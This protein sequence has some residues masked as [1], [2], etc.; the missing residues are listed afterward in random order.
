MERLKNIIYIISYVFMIAALLVTAVFYRQP[1]VSILLVFM[2]ILPGI[3]LFF[4]H[5]GSEQISLSASAPSGDICEGDAFVIRLKLKN[6]SPVP[7]LRCSLEYSFYNL[8]KKDEKKYVITLPGESFASENYN[9][10]F[11]AGCAGMFVFEGRELLISD[12][13][14]FHT[15]RKK[16]D[17]NISI[18]VMPPE[19]PIPE[20][21]LSRYEGEPLDD[22]ISENGELTRDIRQLREYRAGDRLKDIHWKASASSGELM[23]KEYER[24]VDLSYLLLPETVKGDEENVLRRYYSLGKKLIGTGQ[25]FRTAIYEPADRTFSYENVSDEDSFIR[26][27]YEIMTRGSA[28]D[29]IYQTFCYQNPGSMGVIRICGQSIIST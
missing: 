28:D 25:G 24:S 13:L 17:I 19:I 3:S 6:P 1:L 11:R 9:M 23:V 27:M 2:L 4:G 16:C 21:N 12:P 14:H 18:P 10:T 29:D 15:F 20:M 22:V 26:S 5:Y 7:L 8:Y